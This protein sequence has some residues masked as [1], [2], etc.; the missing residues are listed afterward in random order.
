MVKEIKLSALREEDHGGCLVRYFE[1]SEDARKQIGFVLPP[2]V[3]DL[4][5][6][7]PIGSSYKLV[8]DVS[9]GGNIQGVIR[10]MSRPGKF[11]PKINVRFVVEYPELIREIYPTILNFAKSERKLIVAAYFIN[12]YEAEKIETLLDIGFIKGAATVKTTCLYGKYYD[13][14]Y[15]YHDIEKEYEDSPRREYAEKGDLYPMLPVEKRKEPLKLSF[16]LANLDDAADI[17]E[18]ISQQNTFRTLAGGVYE[19]YESKADEASY[20]E[21]GKKSGLSFPV[22]CVDTER[23]KVIGNST[24]GIMNDQV[25]RHTGHLGIMI[26]PQY[27]GLGVGTALLKEI[28]LLAKRIHLENLVLSYFEINEAGKRLYEKSGYKYRGEVPGWLSTRYMKEIFM[29]KTL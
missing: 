17:A 22:V 21:Q 4:K 27:H 5:S 7:F 28:D 1:V 14:V 3:D 6:T 23:N 29:Q 19:G 12:G 24:L 2:S 20:L 15:L 25:T 16:R 11:S 13:T 26:H 8:T 18:A 10:A 9:S